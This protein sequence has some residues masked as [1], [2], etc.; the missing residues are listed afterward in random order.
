MRISLETD[1]YDFIRENIRHWVGKSFGSQELD[2]PSWNIDELSSFLANKINKREETI[3]NL[4]DKKLVVYTRLQ[5]QK[6]RS[7]LVAS[8]LEKVRRCGGSSR[9]IIYGDI[10]NVDGV[11]CYEITFDIELPSNDRFAERGMLR[12]LE[13]QRDGHKNIYSFALDTPSCLDSISYEDMAQRVWNSYHP[14]FN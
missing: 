9:K 3:K 6:D 4:T 11:E 7:A 5:S 2:D 14:I 1:T 13:R 12:W 8:I 10:E